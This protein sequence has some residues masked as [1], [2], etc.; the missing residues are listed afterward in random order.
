MKTADSLI[1]TNVFY[2]QKQIKCFDQLT[3]VGMLDIGWL[4]PIFNIEPIS[5]ISTGSGHPYNR[6][7]ELCLQ[8]MKNPKLMKEKSAPWIRL[9]I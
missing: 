4:I 5:I 1:V 3:S 6:I 7:F 2:K 8:Q 9:L